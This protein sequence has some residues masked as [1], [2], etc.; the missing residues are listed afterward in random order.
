[1]TLG[2]IGTLLYFFFALRHAR[3]KGFLHG[4][5]SRQTLWKQ[6]QLSLPSSLQQ[7]FFSAGVVGLLWIVSRI[8]STPLL[9][10]Q[11]VLFSLTKLMVTFLVT[12]FFLIIAAAILSWVGGSMRH[13][14]I[15]LVYQLT[16]PVMRPIRKIIPPIAGIDLS[17][18]FALIG[19]RFLLLL[20]GW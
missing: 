16:E 7:L 2:N 6:F 3:D 8:G 12:Y 18:L 5:P 13:P 4:L 10:S 15:P 1:M 17:P 19:I 9:P 14:F 20:L 11:I